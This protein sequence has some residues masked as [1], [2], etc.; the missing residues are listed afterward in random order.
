M[1]VP[2]GFIVCV[3]VP[4]PATQTKAG[5]GVGGGGEKGGKCVGRMKCLCQFGVKTWAIVKSVEAEQ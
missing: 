4:K 1:R 5:G 2:V 3:L